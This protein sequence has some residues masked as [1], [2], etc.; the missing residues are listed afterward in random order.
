MK[1]LNQ[2]RFELADLESKLARETVLREQG[3]D[4]A[5]VILDL[6]DE[7]E[8]LDIEIMAKEHEE[9]TIVS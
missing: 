8:R 7:I 6:Q 1:T 3:V 5:N 4:N 9:H 2:L